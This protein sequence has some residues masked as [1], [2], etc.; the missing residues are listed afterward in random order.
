[1]FAH[2]AGQST[3]RDR[4]GGPW[5]GISGRWVWREG[6]MLSADLSAGGAG[7]VT[8]LEGAPLSDPRTAF[9]R[10]AGTWQR[11][12]SPAPGIT[13]AAGWGYLA[14][15]EVMDWHHG[16]ERWHWER[17]VSALTATAGATLA[18]APGHRLLLSI[19]L[20]PWATW[21]ES[22][23]AVDDES[24]AERRWRPAAAPATLARVGGSWRYPLGSRW[25]IG[26]WFEAFFA[27]SPPIDRHE[28]AY[29]GPAGNTE[30]QVVY[31]LPAVDQRAYAYGAMLQALF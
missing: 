9:L 24:G 1:T 23:R 16:G 10:V 3:Y 26:L 29:T 15:R 17:T 11:T 14:D 6:Q 5:L 28:Q 8:I 25:Q 13:L 12:L 20:S 21:Q 4:T 7:H 18:M 31:A 30:T 19:A 27:G 22:T 2:R